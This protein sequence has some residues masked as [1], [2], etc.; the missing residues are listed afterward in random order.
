MDHK[1]QEM[2]LQAEQELRLNEGPLA[3]A[4][5]M[6]VALL[7]FCL[8][9]FLI[10]LP[11]NFRHLQVIVEH[12]DTWTQLTY[13]EA[14]MLRSMGLSMQFYAVYLTLLE[15][16]VVTVFVAAGI[17][18]FWFRREDG[19][20]IFSSAV[21]ILFGVTS[22][23]AIDALAASHFIWRIPVGL[24]S[25]LGLSST[26]ILFFIFP[27]GKFVPGWTRW[28]ALSWTAWLL[29]SVVVPAI[30]PNQLPFPLPFLIRLLLFGAGMFAQIYRYSK[31]L[32]P[33]QKQQ[34]KWV[35][36]GFTAA[37]SGF[38]LFNLPFALS[39][40]FNEPGLPRLLFILVGYPLISLLPMM[41]VPVSIGFA[42]LRY[43][44]WDID[45]LINRTAV[46]SLL[47]GLL[48]A[49]YFGLV[50]V[51]QALFSGLAGQSNPGIITVISTLSIAAIFVPLR[52]RVQIGIDQRFF[53]SKIDAS[54]ILSAFGATLR[55]EI[56]LSRLIERLE[57]MI[58]DTMQPAHVF[59]WLENGQGF[60][61]FGFEGDSRIT[62]PVD[63]PLP[64][65][66]RTASGLTVLEELDLDSVYFQ[67]FRSHHV[68]AILPL[69]SRGNLIGW[70]SLGPR[71]S[72]QGYGQDDRRLLNTLAS[73]A[74]PAV[75]VAHLLLK[76]KEAALERERMEYELGLA[77]TI[78]QTLLPRTLPELPGWSTAAHY[79]PARSVGGDFY[80]FLLFEDG[81]LGVLIGDVTDKGI[82]ASLVMAATRSVLRS[83]AQELVSPGQVLERANH[84][85]EP[86]IP[87]GMFVTC[88]YLLLDPGSGRVQF[89]NAGHCLPVTFREER[90]GS[91]LSSASN[92]GAERVVRTT[93]ELKATGMPLG[94]MDGMKYEEKEAALQP[95]EGLLLYSDGLIEVH[96]PRRE[97]LGAAGLR[98][99][100]E[101]SQST[102]QALIRELMEGLAAFT[103]EGWEQEDDVTLTVIQRCASE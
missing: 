66:L 34:T 32:T 25:A 98:S 73:Q 63:D 88:L 17:L 86:D 67:Q 29:A 100:L 102:D 30:N 58:F 38:I 4:R 47:T 40:T 18:I 44:L 70:L 85:L 101:G 74:A 61:I 90:A 45:I 84:L 50:I 21:A 6:W 57:Q 81:R 59:T 103:G 99:I 26:L 39:E 83:V 89:A 22:V 69:V 78:Q 43:K 24:L 36:Y 53:R 14:F 72:D 79:Q 9:Y 46:Y 37:F 54:K 27:D 8:G 5:V 75:Q 1:T 51:L 31:R 19:M 23:P 76:H 92:P 7:I 60:R 93:C 41:L 3:L 68:K 97:M 10:A 65:A 49:I 13:V 42:V 11:A 56:D 80:D 33:L 91:R 71:M 55:E 28:L 77:R 62:I 95:G 15:I 12:A 52:R 2:N 64:Q 82:P 94:L 48:A 96:N 87:P 20:A 16:L 35:V